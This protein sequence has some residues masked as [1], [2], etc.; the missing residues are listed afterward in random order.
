MTAT[1]Y[2]QSLIDGQRISSIPVQLSELLFLQ[3]LLGQRGSGLLAELEKAKQKMDSATTCHPN[4]VV[5]LF[6][7]AHEILEA[8]IGRLKGGA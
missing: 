6:A 4:A 3:L 2:L 8:V 5:H 7:E 1:E